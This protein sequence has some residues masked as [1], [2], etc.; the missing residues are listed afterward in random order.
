[1]IEIFYCY[2]H[3]D[4]M[5]RSGL[6]TH[7]STLKLLELISGWHEGAIQSGK[8]RKREI[9]IHLNNANI[10]L[11]LVSSNFMA[12]E[13]CHSIMRQA[14]EKHEAGT[15]YVIPIILRPVDLVNTLI[16]KLQ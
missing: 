13:Q 14:F 16:G 1:M 10:I 4:A 11:L 8:E 5:L 2:A 9:D 6:E 15:A 7:L 12:S 3:E